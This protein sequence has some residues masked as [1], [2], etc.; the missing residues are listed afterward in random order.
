MDQDERTMMISHKLAVA[1][2]NII[3]LQNNFSADIDI[4]GPSFSENTR[5]YLQSRLKYL[6]FSEL[7]IYIRE[8]D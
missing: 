1:M 8:K 5:V 3:S 7:S 2:S 6:N 4:Y